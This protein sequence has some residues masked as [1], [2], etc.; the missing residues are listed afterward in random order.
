M[1]KLTPEIY[2]QIWPED[3]LYFRRMGSREIS[4][5]VDAVPENERL[6]LIT[7]GVLEAHGPWLPVANDT[8]MA[9][10]AT[11]VVA[12][13]LQEEQDI[14][15]I[16][17]NSFAD[18]GSY[19]ATRDFPGAVAVEKWQEYEDG[20]NSPMLHT[21]ESFIER[22]Q[23]EGF[24]RFFLVNGDGGNWMN[25]WERPWEDGFQGIKKTLEEKYEVILDGANWDQD[26]G[27]PWKHAGHHEHAFM[28]WLCWY[29]PD[30][31]KAAAIR[32]GLKAVDEEKLKT[33]DGTDFGDIE[34]EERRRENWSE[35][36]AQSELRAVTE[37]SF[38]EYKKLL[39]NEDGSLRTTG[40]IIDDFHAKIEELYSKINATLKS[41]TPNKEQK[42]TL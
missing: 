14:Q 5:Y 17:V 18:V 7:W 8:I 38:D 40:G 35:N 22:L 24:P 11:D 15:P 29:A 3:L 4:E 28:N 41:S 12:R 23:Q 6:I 9:Q 2:D 26:G 30:F 20:K 31:E 21:W 39:Y 33:I 36:P 25:Y 13:R 27:Y 10:V 32:A 34:D 37:F 1:E 16:I 19:S 42:N